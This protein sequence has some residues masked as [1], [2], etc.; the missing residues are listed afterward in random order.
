MSAFVRQLA[1]LSV[2]WSLCELLTPSGGQ[3]RMARLAVSLLVMTALV[4]TL[5]EALNGAGASAWAALPVLAEGVQSE[6]L[7]RAA[8]QSA[9]DQTWRYCEGVARRAGY[10]ARGQVL[11][12]QS[13]ALER[14]CLYLTV[15][16]GG[17]PLVEPEGLRDR[18]VQA[19]ATEPERIQVLWAEG[20]E[21]D[22]GV[23]P[24]ESGP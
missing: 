17:A 13:G 7:A 3:R 18:L 9:A 22:H 4:A 20:Q 21:T 6:S 8:V 19:L 1:A 23:R 5:G 2:L 11:L 24:G 10:Q 12:S 14:V 15:P 16:Q